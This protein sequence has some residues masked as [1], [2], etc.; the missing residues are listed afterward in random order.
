VSLADGLAQLLA[1]Y[2]QQPKTPEQM[3]EEDVVRN[4]QAPA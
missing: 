1:W 2:R 3:L 4:W